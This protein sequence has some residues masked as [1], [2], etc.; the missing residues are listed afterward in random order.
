MPCCPNGE[1]PCYEKLPA[2]QLCNYSALIIRA[3]LYRHSQQPSSLKRATCTH[4][5]SASCRLDTSCGA[6]QFW[7]YLRRQLYVMDT[8]C[9]AHNKHLNHTML[10]LHSYL[11]WAF[12]I[13]VILTGIELFA[14]LPLWTAGSE[15]RAGFLSSGHLHMSLI[16]ISCKGIACAARVAAQ[17]QKTDHSKEPIPG[18]HMTC[19]TAA[20]SVQPSLSGSKT[21]LK[22]V[23]IAG[24]WVYQGKRLN[25]SCAFSRRLCFCPALSAALGR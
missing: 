22:K 5:H 10:A 25:A 20:L 13:P 18:R 24:C 23:L 9:N 14:A 12:I 6:Q 15:V 19:T 11:S 8:Y 17:A 1:P 3:V 21:A 16:T 4:L 2:S 7:N